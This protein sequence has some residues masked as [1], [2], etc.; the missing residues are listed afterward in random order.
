LINI[1]NEDALYEHLSIEAS[2]L[3]LN[4]IN[5]YI[6]NRYKKENEYNDSV[7]FNNGRNFTEKIERYNQDLYFTNYAGD[8]KNILLNKPKP[9]RIVYDSVNDIYAIGSALKY[10]HNDLAKMI[11]DSGYIYEVDKNFDNF[12][13][14]LMNNGYGYDNSSAYEEYM[15]ERGYNRM[16]GLFFIPLDDS[17]EK[18]EKTGF[19]S[20]E[21]EITTGYIYVQFAKYFSENGIFSDLYKSL[22]SNIVSEYKRKSLSAIWNNIGEENNNMAIQVRE[23][24]EDAT[25]EGY[26]KNEI[27][28]YLRNAEDHDLE[29]LYWKH[30]KSRFKQFEDVKLQ[31]AIMRRDAK[32]FTYT[33]K[34]INDFLKSVGIDT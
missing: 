19:Y 11:V 22:K 9:Y 7:I 14:K 8:V 30:F 13:T 34:E 17:Y 18:Y 16:R 12:I 21:I 20:A 31:T 26:S 3:M 33:D 27:N 1:I 24:I 25:N 10:T 15:L 29:S 4:K 32:L 5:R 23:F 28:D 6:N 2:K